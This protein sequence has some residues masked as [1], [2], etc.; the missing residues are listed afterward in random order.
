MG[1]L[2]NDILT[3][4]DLFLLLMMKILMGIL[5]KYQ[6]NIKILGNIIYLKDEEITSEYLLKK[7]AYVQ[8][9]MILMDF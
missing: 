1:R 4:Y 5:K 8:L 3:C 6:S 7:V 9:Y 2:E